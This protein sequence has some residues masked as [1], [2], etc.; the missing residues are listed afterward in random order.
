[1]SSVLSYVTSPI[2]NYVSSLIISALSKY[3]VGIEVN[4]TYFQS[5]WFEALGILSQELNLQNVEL[6]L[7]SLENDLG[8]ALPIVI[9]SSFAK[10]LK[11]VIPWTSLL[12]LPIGVY[13]ENLNIELEDKVGVIFPSSL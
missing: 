10:S 3:I 8:I 12:S 7:T 9:K 5:L 1:M 13:I 6:N 4:C 11:I 2:R